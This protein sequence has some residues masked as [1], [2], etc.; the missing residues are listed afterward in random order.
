MMPNL[1]KD[2]E[3]AKLKNLN[4]ASLKIQLRYQSTKPIFDEVSSRAL[5]L[6][7]S[8][9][10]DPETMGDNLQKWQLHRQSLLSAESLRS[11]TKECEKSEE[12]QKLWQEGLFRATDTNSNI[13][14][15][16]PSPML[17]IMDHMT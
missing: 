2:L 6:A 8:L 10:D 7:T 14:A 17:A 12:V 13:K 15:V 3:L 5:S 9:M 16:H 11:I 1:Y 4:F